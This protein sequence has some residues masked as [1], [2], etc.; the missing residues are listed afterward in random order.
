M[1]DLAYVVLIIGGFSACALV[2][3]GLQGSALKSAGPKS[4]GLGS[5]G[6]R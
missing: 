1:A 3:R 6:N 5:R 4:R 2:L